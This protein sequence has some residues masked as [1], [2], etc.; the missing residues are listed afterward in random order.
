MAEAFK[1]VAGQVVG[2]ASVSVMLQGGSVVRSSH[3]LLY[4]PFLL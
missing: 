3:S 4:L 2:A 1:E